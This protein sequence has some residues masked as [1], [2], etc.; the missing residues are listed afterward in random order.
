MVKRQNVGQSKCIEKYCDSV[1]DMSHTNCFAVLQTA[2]SDSVDSNS[3]I[4]LVED[5][6]NTDCQSGVLSRLT[7]VSRGDIKV[8]KFLK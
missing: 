7:M 2:D 3:S 1:V 6:C 8:R 4:S 5:A